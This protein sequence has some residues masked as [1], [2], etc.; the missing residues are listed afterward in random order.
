MLGPPPRRT[1]CP[2]S[3]LYAARSGT[4]CTAAVT[5][6]LRPQ[7]NKL[8][9]TARGSIS[10][11][12]R[13]LFANGGG[14]RS[15]CCPAARPGS[16]ARPGRAFQRPG[17][18]TMLLNFLRGGGEKDRE[19]PQATRRAISKRW[20]AG[21]LPN[22]LILLLPLLPFIKHSSLETPPSVPIPPAS[23]PAESCQ[24]G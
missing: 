1:R 18:C 10:G 6:A 21:V 4:A 16:V 23:G 2:G 12:T 3:T 22:L 5:H 14:G 8:S 17:R 24:T 11:S 13:S 9:S 20:V 7:G 15:R 19:T